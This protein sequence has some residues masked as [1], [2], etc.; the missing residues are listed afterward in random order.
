MIHKRCSKCGQLNPVSSRKCARCGRAFPAPTAEIKDSSQDELSLQAS[1]AHGSTQAGF[2]PPISSSDGT[3][4][5]L[6]TF[7][8]KK[9][10]FC[11][12]NIK[13]DAVFCRF[14]RHD[15]SDVPEDAR[16]SL[17]KTQPHVVAPPTRLLASAPAS[18]IAVGVEIILGLLG[19]YGLGHFL[20]RRWRSGLGFLLFTPLWL[21]VEGVT[22]DVLLAGNYPVGWCAL[23]FHMPVMYI[24]VI[25]LEGR[26]IGQR[27]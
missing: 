25:L 9:C 26:R 11:A 2:E 14:C 20:A 15:L 5:P 4:K 18:R 10:P 1:L 17:P 22:K 23:T 19:I 6:P 16:R 7:G 24:S 12:E 13:A 21:F 3:T 8:T 27:I